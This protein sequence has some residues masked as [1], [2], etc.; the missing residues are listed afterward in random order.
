MRIIP[1]NIAS[2][3]EVVMVGLLEDWTSDLHALELD[4]RAERLVGF[5]N[6]PVM[7]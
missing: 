4:G 2:P 6:Q 5:V 1:L 7:P 3:V